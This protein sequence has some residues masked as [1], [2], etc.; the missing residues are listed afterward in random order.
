MRERLADL[1][2][3]CERWQDIT[4]EWDACD[5]ECDDFAESEAFAGAHWSAASAELD[6][7]LGDVADEC[8]AVRGADGS[9]EAGAF[10]DRIRREVEAYDSARCT[11]IP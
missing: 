10:E 6:Q 8:E 1:R 4:I 11:E 9:G 3:A 7:A 5:E 2:A